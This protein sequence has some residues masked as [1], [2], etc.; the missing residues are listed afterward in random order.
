M[1]RDY[2]N[3]IFKTVMKDETTSHLS[4][5]D[6]ILP[7]DLI[8]EPGVRLSFHCRRR[9]DSRKDYRPRIMS[10]CQ[11]QLGNQ[12]IFLPIPG[13]LL[14]SGRRSDVHKIMRESGFSDLGYDPCSRLQGEHVPIAID[15][16]PFELK[17]WSQ[18][19]AHGPRR[20]SHHF[21][22]DLTTRSRG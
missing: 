8:W 5:F 20:W 18:L 2:R 17:W 9:Q 7:P 19:V 14:T 1:T 3:I 12:V 11:H 10:R 13:N 16:M 4:C 15:V 21:D 6:N 22:A